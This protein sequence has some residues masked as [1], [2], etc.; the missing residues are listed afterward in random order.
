M[1]SAR[2]LAGIELGGTKAIAI[3][4][5][6]DAVI[7]EVTVPTGPPT[8]TLSALRDQLARWNADRAL[9][10]LGIASFGPLMLDRASP[11]FGTML[12]TPKPGWSGAAIAA[13]ADGL[14]C[15]WT[16]DTD[17]NGAALAE[18]RHGAGRG[19][20]VLCYVTLG[21]GVGGGLTIDGRPLHGALHPE[22][23]HLTLRRAPGDSFAGQCAFHSDCIEGLVS[24]PA[25]SAR[26]G[27]DA[28]T[29]ADTDPRWRDV[30]WDLAQLCG[31]ILLTTSA[32]RILF[33]GSVAVHRPFLLP[34]V[35]DLLVAQLG[36]YLPFLTRAAADAIVQPA[37]L[38]PRAG[39]LGAIALADT[40]LDAAAAG[41][42]AMCDAK[43]FAITA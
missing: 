15:P 19:C 18:F 32:N 20:A 38:G 6:G 27:A 3:L 29:V 4:A 39:P 13:L 30:A 42:G 37:A 21:T 34:M 23:G 35:R 9:D 12:A 22:I 28:A 24:G 8:E 31:A 43:N 17:V 16:I 40:A 11:V 7:D 2:R 25:L 1:S 5:E 36:S 26:F 41:Q 14:A 33:G 10:A